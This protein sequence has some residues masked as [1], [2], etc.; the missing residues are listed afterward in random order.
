MNTTNI[1]LTSASVF[2]YAGELF[3]GSKEYPYKYNAKIQLEGGRFSTP[4]AF[5]GDVE[6]GNKILAN[7][8]TIK[9]YGIQRKYLFR[10]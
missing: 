5:D 6:G 2:I 3:I 10:L 4:I 1:T 8:G 7:V 9:M